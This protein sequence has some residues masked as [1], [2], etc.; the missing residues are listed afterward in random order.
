MICLA[1]QRGVVAFSAFC[2]CF[3]CLFFVCDELLF[4]RAFLG[5]R[6]GGEESDRLDRLDLDDSLDSLKT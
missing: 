6:G 5:V 2:D 3:I 4:S 1:W